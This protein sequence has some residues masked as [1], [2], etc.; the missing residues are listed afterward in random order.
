[1][2]ALVTILVFSIIA[3]VDVITGY[4]SGNADIAGRHLHT[5]CSAAWGIWLVH[6]CYAV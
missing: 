6:N 4:G 1:M 2:S 3:L 5:A